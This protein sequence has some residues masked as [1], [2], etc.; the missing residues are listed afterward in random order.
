MKIAFF[1]DKVNSK[2]KYFDP[3]DS[4]PGIGGTQYLIWTYSYYLAKYTDIEII[5]FTPR[6]LPNMGKVVQIKANSIKDCLEH[7]DCQQIDYF[8]LRGP[9]IKNEDWKY[10]DTKNIRIILW[11]HNFEN[12]ISVKN[13]KKHNSFFFDICVSKSQLLMMKDTDTFSKCTFIYNGINFE[14]YSHIK[15]KHVKHRMCYIGNLYPDS[16]YL[17]FLK[18]WDKISCKY[19]DSELY[20]IGG[21]NL[22]QGMDSNYSRKSL[23]KEKRIEH[24]YL[25][26]HGKLKSNIHFTGVIGGNDK[27][28]LMASAEV[29][30]ANITCAGETF[31][32]SAIEFEALGVPVVSLNKFGIRETVLNEKTG[33]LVDRFGDIH[34]AV[35]RLFDNNEL[36]DNLSTNAYRFVR[37]EF[38]IKKIIKQW[39][40]FLK[41]PACYKPEKTSLQLKDYSSVYLNSVFRNK[42]HLKIIPPVLFYKYLKYGFRRLLQKK[43]II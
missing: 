25:Y 8:I 9:F 39:N 42:Y 16:G 11:S 10:L 5:L 32:L 38:D 23:S 18:E 3:E 26:D 13:F 19:P 28:K 31:G 34:L 14:P 30:V 43:E 6:L 2:I 15:E 33:I 36:R 41:N 21:H 7:Y 1:L 40:Y 24:D 17:Q 37:D 4:N 22:Y 12:Y 29:G 35:D 27:L 20:I